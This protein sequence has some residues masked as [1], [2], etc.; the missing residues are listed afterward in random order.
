[1]PWKKLSP[2]MW[3]A[4]LTAWLWSVPRLTD[5][6]TVAAWLGALGTA[7]LFALAVGR[8]GGMSARVWRPLA[9]AVRPPDCDAV[10]GMA[11]LDAQIMRQLGRA[12]QLSEKS[13]LDM[14]G[15]VA[16]LHAASAHFMRYLHEAQTQNDAMQSDVEHNSHI[17]DE[18]A[19]FVQR[20]PQQLADE[21]RQFDQV[22]TEVQKLSALSDTIRLIARQTEILAINAAVEA[23][24]AGDSGRGFAVLAG[25]VRRLATQTNESAARIGQDITRLVETVEDGFLGGFQARVEHHESESH[26]LSDLSHRLHRS[27]IDMR[28]FYQTLMTAVGQHH[29][30]LDAGIALL[31]DAGQYQDVF[32]QIIDR[33]DP[34]LAERRALV[35][36]LI[37]RLRGGQTATQDLDER[38][39]ALSRTYLAS[40]AM[41]RD[42]DE[43][44]QAAPGLPAARIELF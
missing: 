30:E 43:N 1:M 36:E 11:A 6:S 37:A 7:A 15:R 39:A 35:E 29:G 12:V 18:L 19:S 20:L 16:S 27:Y 24:R 28:A 4:C 38:A 5:S 40:E 25:E 21:R 10:H 2:A 32:K 22:V 31:S 14:V 23:A 33:V 41:H 8:D 42:P 44:A 9:D 26:R 13:A 34:A 3:L 17:I